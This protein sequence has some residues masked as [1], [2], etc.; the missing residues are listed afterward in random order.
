[1]PRIKETVAFCSRSC[2]YENFCVPDQVQVLTGPRRVLVRKSNLARADATR[3]I[4]L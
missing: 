4:E 3:L 1:M 2:P